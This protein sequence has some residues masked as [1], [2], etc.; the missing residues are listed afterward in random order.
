VG[1]GLR[2]A[3]N[4]ELLEHTKIDNGRQNGQ[5][6]QSESSNTGG[7]PCSSSSCSDPS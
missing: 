3:G 6:E 1:C 7:S 4:N 5:Q 2:I